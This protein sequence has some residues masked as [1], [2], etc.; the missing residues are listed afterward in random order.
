[1]K[2]CVIGAGIIGASTA[3]HLSRLGCDVHLIDEAPS[4]GLVTSYA[5][6]AQLSY[7]Y[8]EP[9]ASPHTLNALPSLLFGADSPLKFKLRMDWR[10]WAWG[11]Q[12]LKACTTARVEDGTRQLLELAQL[13]RNT[14]DDWMSGESWSFD[15]KQNGKLVLC[16][17]YE[18]LRHQER[19]IAFQQQFGCQQEVLGKLACMQKEPAL[20][21]YV[22]TFAGAVWTP[23]ERIA[24]PYQLTRALFKS[25]MKLGAKATF[26]TSVTGFATKGDCVTALQTSAGEIPADAFVLASGITAPKLASALGIYLP[27]YPIKGYSLTLKLRDPGRAPKTS[28]TDLARKTVFA[29]LGDSLRVAAMAEVGEGD[30]S[31]SPERVDTMIASVEAVFPGAC[32]LSNVRTWAGLRPATPDSLPLLGRR[33]F[34]NFYLNTGHGAL[35]LTLAAGSAVVVGK[36]LLAK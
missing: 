8:V 24:D 22:G 33:K 16:Q 21:N 9:L 3:Y 7:S 1:M 6:G 30:L 25:A 17:T 12:F 23:D 20:K 26:E 28:V 27:I 29:P 5:N 19:Q 34:E 13:S 35:G 18:S 31:I 32:D 14:L 2:V 36:Q 11:L 4:P 10:Q 15:H